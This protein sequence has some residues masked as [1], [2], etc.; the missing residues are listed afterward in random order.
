MKSNLFAVLFLALTNAFIL[1]SVEDVF[2]KSG[3]AQFIFGKVTTVDGD[4]YQGQIR[5]GNEEAFWFDFFNSTKEE[6]DNLKWLDRKQEQALNTQNHGQ[7]NWWGKWSKNSWSSSSHQHVFACQFGDLKSIQV[8]QGEKLTAEFKNGESYVLEGGSNDVGAQVQVS[9]KELGTIKL[10]WHRIESV[11][12][13]QAPSGME[14]SFGEALYGTVKTIRGEFEGYLQWDHDERLTHDVLNGKTEDGEL[15]IEF[16]KIQ[17]IKRNYKGSHVTLT[18]GRSFDMWGSNDVNHE[19]RG[20]IVS[21]PN[22]GRV[23]IPWDEFEEMTISSKSGGDELYY[24]DYRGYSTLRGSVKTH[25]GRTVSGEIVYDLDEKYGLEMLDG[26]A[27]DIDYFI[28]FSAVKSIEPKNRE[29]SKITLGNGES[30]ILG[31]KV[32]VSDDND[33]ILVFT[34][35]K[36]PEYIAWSEVDIVTFE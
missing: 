11:E 23:D 2:G 33:G 22:Y 35:N 20:I 19:N 28:P 31:D 24:D 6:N 14:S 17:S 13:M 26:S 16:G 3:S 34:G 32:D 30:F 7:H 8:H 29:E 27:N 12:F 25:D 15:D 36:D 9:D 21:T 10:D 4:V 1:N 5:W 18:S